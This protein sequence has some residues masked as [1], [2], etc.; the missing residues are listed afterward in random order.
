M[1]SKT[2]KC[3]S[4]F[5]LFAKKNDFLKTENAEKSMFPMVKCI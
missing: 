4:V 1:P 5:Q 3:R 2:E